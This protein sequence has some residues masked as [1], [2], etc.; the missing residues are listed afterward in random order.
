MEETSFTIKQLKK[1]KDAYAS[2]VLK[3]QINDTLMVY[4]D[5][6]HLL[7]AIRTMEKELNTQHKKM[8]IVPKFNKGL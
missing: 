3:V 8:S 5:S 2:G 7:K 6:N 4:Q 1:L